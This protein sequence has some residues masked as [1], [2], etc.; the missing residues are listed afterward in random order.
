VLIL[1]SYKNLRLQTGWLQV[2]SVFVRTASSPHNT[3]ARSTSSN[4]PW[5]H[6]SGSGSSSKSASVDGSSDS[7][8]IINNDNYPALSFPGYA[9]KPLAEQL[10]PIAVVGMGTI[11]LRQ[12]VNNLT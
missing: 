1:K 3:V 8:P 6:D 2:A 9:E 5:M 12:S 7:A 4:M 10:E 11:V